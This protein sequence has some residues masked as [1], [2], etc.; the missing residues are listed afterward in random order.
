MKTETETETAQ[1][2]GEEEM[3]GKENINLEKKQKIYHYRE[4]YTQVI[5]IEQEEEEE[6]QNLMNEYK[7][8]YLL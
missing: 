5:T 3:R 1:E 2:L 8:D 4:V 6:D 7:I